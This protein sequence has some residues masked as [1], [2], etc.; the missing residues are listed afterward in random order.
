MSMT[1]S[2]LRP[3]V[4]IA[5]PKPDRT[6]AWL[7]LCT[8]VLSIGAFVYFSVRGVTLSYADSISHLEIARRVVDSPTADLTQLG[9]VWLPLPHLLSLP[10]IWLDSLYFSG[11]AGSVVSM[12][13][14]VVTCVFL[15]KI[16]YTLTGQKLAGIVTAA[17]FALNPNVLYMQST[18]MTELLLFACMAAM[19]YNAQRWIQ[20]GQDVYLIGAGISS[21]LGSMTRYEAWVLLAALLIVMIIAARRKGYGYTR[22]E[23][24]MLAFVAIG[25]LGAA[26]WLIWN[27]LIFGNGL[28]F[29][30]GE[31][32]KPSLWV[33]AAEVA[34]G[35]W[36]VA[37][38]SYSIA[39][40][41]NLG[42]ALIVLAG[43]GFI[44]LLVRRLFSLA[45]FPTMAL[46]VLFPFF[47]V[48]LESGQRPLHVAEVSG[49]LYNVRFGLLMILPAAILTGCLVYLCFGYK[50][51]ER[52]VASVVL[53]CAAVF[54]IAS[55]VQP[56]GIITLKEPLAFAAASHTTLSD[57]ASVYLRQY[58]DTGDIL[59]ES[60]GNELVLFDAGITPQRNIYEGSYRLWEPALKD[61]AAQHVRWIVMRGGDQPDKVSTA[62]NASSALGQYSLV[63]Q[64]DTYQIFKER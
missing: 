7:A 30:Y 56:G 53:T 45:V 59:M 51:W 60:F 62:L 23:G 2:R 20:T 10:F 24:S 3:T 35:N 34:V 42:L 61:P 22:S 31:Y 8:A 44:G 13:A 17:V 41:D 33:G 43:I 54:G 16:T 39:V 14:Y 11:F 29:L 12:I 38:Q 6:V 40:V 32:A 1:E 63:Y 9:G 5:P 18:P 28:G 36:W 57:E 48:A 25:G 47:V 64:N 37:L 46:L 15:Y 58:Y 21:L 19:V 26:S 55:F 52:I 49:D 50:V 4:P 27:Q